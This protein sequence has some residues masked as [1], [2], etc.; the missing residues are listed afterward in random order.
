MT[1]TTCIRIAAASGFITVA[2]GAFGAHGLK[3]ILDKYET[4]PTWETAVL[5]Q[6]FHSL[7]LLALALRPT[8]NTGAV[9]SFVIGICIFSGSL[10]VLSLTNIR[11]LGAITP[12][13]GAALLI[14]WI[15]WFW[16]A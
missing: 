6:M 4:G 10:Y 7:A 14:G 5:Y 15:L 9:I 1:S 13:G 3:G 11:W 8:V 2:L 16:K 12:V